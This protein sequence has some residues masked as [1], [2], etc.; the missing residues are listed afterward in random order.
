MTNG[1]ASNIVQTVVG[2]ADELDRGREFYARRAWLD[3]FT[4]LSKADELAPLS[5]PDLELLATAASLTGRM[6]E[7]L[8]LLE[9]AHLAHIE[10][11]ENLAAAGCAGWLGMTLAIRGDMGP[12]GGWFA[13][14]SASGRPGRAGLRRAGLPPDSGRLP[15]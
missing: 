9:R 15:V 3:A 2:A 1:P 11:G 4:A 13:P 7:Y 14:V 5:A 8:A 6:D 12:A 10:A